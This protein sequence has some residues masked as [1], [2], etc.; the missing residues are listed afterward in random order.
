MPSHPFRIF[1]QGRKETLY[2]V[3]EWHFIQDHRRELM[4]VHPAGQLTQHRVPGVCGDSLHEK[5]LVRHT[6][7]QLV[8][9]PEQWLE[10]RKY[11]FRHRLERRMPRRIHDI[12][13]DADRKLDQ[14]FAEF[15]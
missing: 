11:P 12:A 10:A 5:F 14:E 3:C 1:R 7:G 2:L 15:T 6:D 8:G 9:I 13:M 4:G